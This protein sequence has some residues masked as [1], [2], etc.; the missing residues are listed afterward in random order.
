MAS[1]EFVAVTWNP[2][3]LVDQDTLAQLNNNLIYLRD[4]MV[5]GS[6]EH[7][8]GSGVVPTGIK[9]LCGRKVVPPRDDDNATATVT[10]S[11]M[12]T[13]GT[14]PVVTV[15]PCIP[16]SLANLTWGIDGIGTDHPTHQG[17]RIRTRVQANL[18]K[19]D[20]ISKPVYF[21]WIAMGT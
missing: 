13:P 7:V 20:K 6:Y 2:Q 1:T 9:I 14:T 11:R 12:F 16:G 8:N 19:N 10:F 15:T 4:N 17:F 5:D 3:Q 18:A 21:N